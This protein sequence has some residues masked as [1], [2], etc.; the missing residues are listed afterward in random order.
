VLSFPP[1]LLSEVITNPT[2]AAEHGSCEDLSGRYYSIIPHNFGRRRPT[3]INN[4]PVLKKVIDRGL[5]L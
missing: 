1:Q 2:K 5:S 4:M 3:V